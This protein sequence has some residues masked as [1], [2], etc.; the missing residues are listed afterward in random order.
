MTH[1]NPYI[2]DFTNCLVPVG[3]RIKNLRLKGYIAGLDA[4]LFMDAGLYDGPVQL[5]AWC[6]GGL[7]LAPISEKFKHI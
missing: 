1:P 3:L 4:G 7:V 6:D 5:G 2:M